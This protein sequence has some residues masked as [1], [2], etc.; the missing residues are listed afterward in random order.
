MVRA[1]LGLIT[2]N[3]HVLRVFEPCCPTPAIRLVQAQELISAGIAVE[4]AIRPILPG[5]TDNVDSLT[6]LIQAFAR[7]AV[8]QVVADT[9]F[10]RPAII[11]SLRR[12]LGDSALLERL[13]SGFEQ[14]RRIPVLHGASTAV[15]LP[16]EMRRRIYRNVTEI[17]GEHRITVRICSGMN[18]DIT[19]VPCN[20][21]GDLSLNTLY[22][23]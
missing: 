10:L 11:S 19:D 8:R 20:R 13:L 9:L 17:A 6:S 3:P 12:A 2:T 15:V 14:R 18:P 7:A 16:V 22:T 5:V 21:A 4:G 23:G 1:Q